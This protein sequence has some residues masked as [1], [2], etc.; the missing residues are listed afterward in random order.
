MKD[1]IL[2]LRNKKRKKRRQQKEKEI[3]KR[4]KRNKIKLKKIVR[5]GNKKLKILFSKRVM[6]MV[7]QLKVQEK[8][9]SILMMT[10]GKGVTII[11]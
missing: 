7:G 4:K 9:I 11:R 6:M 8:K 3:R 2:S 5:F 10:S 1:G